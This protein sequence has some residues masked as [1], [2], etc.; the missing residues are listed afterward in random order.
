[1]QTSTC[2]AGREVRRS[3]WA[4]ALYRTLASTKSIHSPGAVTPPANQPAVVASSLS[5][6]PAGNVTVN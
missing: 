2:L 6:R 5:R 1:M 3:R 4:G